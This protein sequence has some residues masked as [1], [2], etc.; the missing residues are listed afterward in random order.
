MITK[1]QAIETLQR[2][3]FFQGQ[4]AGREL[5]ADKPFEVQ[6][7]DIEDFSEACRLLVEYIS[8][9]AEQKWIPVTERLP[10]RECI[11]ISMLK[12][13]PCYK[14]QII[15]WVFKS[16]NCKTGYACDAGEAV[17]CEVTHWMPLPEPPKEVEG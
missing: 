12:G 9:T 15:G 17:L 5:W 13:Q 11:A 14:E 3:D 6:E 10:E 4:R 8:N 1:E 7:K 2:F 16:P